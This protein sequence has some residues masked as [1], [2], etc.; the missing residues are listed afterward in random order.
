MGEGTPLSFGLSLETDNSKVHLRLAKC[1]DKNTCEAWS[2]RYLLGRT[3]T[4]LGSSYL[5]LN[6]N[7]NH[8]WK[9]HKLS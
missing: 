4:E 3:D 9:M 1:D 8:E 5:N 7:L 2:R 6:P